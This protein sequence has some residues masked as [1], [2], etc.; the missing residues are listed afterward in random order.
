MWDAKA[1]ADLKEFRLKLKWSQRRLAEELGC[2]QSTVSRIETGETPN[3]AIRRLIDILRER[4]SIASP[5]EA[6]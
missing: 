1:G 3:G 4:E 6:A 5:N 2:D